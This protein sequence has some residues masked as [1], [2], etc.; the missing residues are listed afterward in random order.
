MEKR[1]AELQK[2]RRRDTNISVSAEDMAF[3]PYDERNVYDM[4]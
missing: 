2:R 1:K 3:E 4:Q